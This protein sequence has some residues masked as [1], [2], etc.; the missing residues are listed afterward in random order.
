MNAEPDE[1]HSTGGYLTVTESPYRT[2]VA[3]AFLEAGVEMGYENRDVNSERQT[4]F[5]IPQGTIRRGSRCSAAKAF[6]RPARLRPNLHVT[7]RSFVHK[8]SAGRQNAVIACEHPEKQQQQQQQNREQLLHPAAAAAADV[9]INENK[10]AWAVKYEKYDE[11]HVVRARK[12][13]ILSGGAL[14]SP[15]VLMHSGVGECSH[16]QEFGI[17]C[18]QN[19]KVGYNLQDHIG[20]GG[21]T[22][23]IKKPVGIIQSRVENVPTIMKYALFGK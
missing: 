4:G 11:I 18:H 12:E 3:T 5:V 10:R 14:M 19:L 9:L 15:H 23:V 8:H 21:L 6:L 13:I 16:L 1:Y 22:F 7:M 2:P 20:I 17:Y